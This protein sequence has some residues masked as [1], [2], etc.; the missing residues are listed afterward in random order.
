MSDTTNTLDDFPAESFTILAFCDTCGHSTPLDRAKV[1]EGLPVDTLRRQPPVH[2][3]RL[4]RDID[5]DPLHRRRWLP[6]R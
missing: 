2:C 1:P 5:P 4:A 6:L 3:V